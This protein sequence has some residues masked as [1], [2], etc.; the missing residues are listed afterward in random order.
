[1]AILI[2]GFDARLDNRP[3][4]FLDFQTFWRS[5]LRKKKTKRGKAMVTIK[6][7]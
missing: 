2:Q 6:R 7:K 4:L 5:G 1:M 3:F